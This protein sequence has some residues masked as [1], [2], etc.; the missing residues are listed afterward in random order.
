MN[1]RYY[2]KYVVYFFLIY[3]L[4]AAILTFYG[5]KTPEIVTHNDVKTEYIHTVELVPYTLPPD[6]AAI[7]ALL[8]CT[9][10]GKVIMSNLG[11]EAT[12]NARLN[13]IIDSLNNLKA[14]FYTN[15]DTVFVPR[16]KIVFVSDS[17]KAE[18]KT[19]YVEKSLT[20][21]QNFKQEVGGWSFGITIF[22]IILFVFKIL[23]KFK[24]L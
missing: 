20:R 23:R 11:I 22:L 5:C 21:W 8:E 16:E 14:N 2:G 13:F 12:K 9:K 24:I 18:I 4:I 6:S 7:S 3:L 1:K 15:P 17:T 19:V 10:S